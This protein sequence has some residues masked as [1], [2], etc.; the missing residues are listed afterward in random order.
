MLLQLSSFEPDDE[1]SWRMRRSEVCR[2]MHLS[3]PCLEVPG[4][5]LP[6]D[7]LFPRQPHPTTPHRLVHT[8]CDKWTGDNH[9]KHSKVMR[10]PTGHCGVLEAGNRLPLIVAS[11]THP[12]RRLGLISRAYGN[13]VV[14]FSI[15]HAI[16]F[17]TCLPL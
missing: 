3:R 5:V 9:S 13:G 14:A 4:F 8:P 10:I 7:F 12:P 16:P 6:V 15:L 17:I 1:L 2:Q 11:R